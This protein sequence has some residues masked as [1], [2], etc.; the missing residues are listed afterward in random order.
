MAG[1]SDG[2]CDDPFNTEYNGQPCDCA[3]CRPENRCVNDGGCY[4]CDGP[5]KGCSRG[6]EEDDENENTEPDL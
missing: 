3:G 6:A 1:W 2:I 5:V 4:E